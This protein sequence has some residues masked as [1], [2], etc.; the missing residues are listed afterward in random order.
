MPSSYE[1]AL[2]TTLVQGVER[3]S[4]RRQIKKRGGAAA[5]SGAVIAAF[6]MFGSHPHGSALQ[7]GSPQQSTGG[8]ATIQLPGG[9]LVHDGRQ[10]TLSEA[11][12]IA[13]F[14]L[15]R[16]STP[17]ASDAEI[18]EVWVSTMS[19]QE[20]AIQYSSG[21]RVYVEISPYTNA[22]QE[23]SRMA[24]SSVVQS[25]VVVNGFPGLLTV[26]DSGSGGSVEF[27]AGDV[28]VD[29]LGYPGASRSDLLALADS[30]ARA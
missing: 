15:L 18:S 23:Y 17:L 26:P 29:I 9:S 8:V 11:E 30:A 12:S 25:S 21:V 2:R 24:A 14:K 3:Y 10:T 1:D 20:V 4:R 19:P 22:S 16:P 6:L 28:R 27:V 5:S 13:T 7:P